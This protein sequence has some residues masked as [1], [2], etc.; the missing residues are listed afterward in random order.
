MSVATTILGASGYCGRRRS[1]ACSRTRSWSSS[2]SAQLPCR[3]TRERPRPAPER[4]AAGVRHQRRGAR[5]RRRARLLLPRRGRPRSSR[6]PTPSSSTSRR[7]PARR[8]RALSGVGTRSAPGRRLA[9]RLELRDS[10]APPARRAA[11]REPGLLR[12]RRPAR[13]RTTR[14]IDRAR[15]HRR[16]CEVGRLRRGAD[17]QGVVACHLG[18]RERLAIKVDRAGA[19]GDRADARLPRLLRPRLLPVER[20]LLRHLLRDR[21]RD[22]R[23]ALDAA[24]AAS[25][26]GAGG[27]SRRLSRVQGTDGAEIGVFTDRSTGTGI[28]VCALDNLAGR[29][30]AGRSNPEHRARAARGTFRPAALRSAGQ[31]CARLRLPL[32]R[33]SPST[34]PFFRSVGELPSS[35]TPPKAHRPRIGR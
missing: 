35:P 17:A 19:P 18:A 3:L 14:G 6:R 2:R 4:V 16:R 11:D 25:P 5:G 23:D 10:G 27:G 8:R 20:G 21:H 33:G 15:R 13:A 34:S 32:H 7:A 24:Y 29:A 28:V 30:R 9:R 12:H 1:T 26:A 22:L 31:A